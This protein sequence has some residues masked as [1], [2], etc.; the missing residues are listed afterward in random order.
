[1]AAIG[2]FLKVENRFERTT[3]TLSISHKVSITSNN[4]RMTERS[5]VYFVK[6]VKCDLGFAKHKLPEGDNHRSY[7][8][9]VL[10]DPSFQ[11]PILA[12]L[13]EADGKAELV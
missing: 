2:Q 6:T 11:G 3:S 5:P 8:S 12:A 4:K 7:L 13:F 1:M 9:L 10:D